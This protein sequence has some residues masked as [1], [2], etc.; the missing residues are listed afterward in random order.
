MIR[1]GPR[2][3]ECEKNVTVVST[4]TGCDVANSATTLHGFNKQK[5]AQKEEKVKSKKVRSKEVKKQR[6]R[7]LF[8]QKKIKKKKRKNGKNQKKK[9]NQKVSHFLK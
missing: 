9:K 2:T 5:R 8:F 7:K 3:S 4:V 6:R 1:L